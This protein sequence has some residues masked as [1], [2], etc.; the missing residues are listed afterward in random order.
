M[1]CT[2]IHT[3]NIVVNVEYN[4]NITFVYSSNFYR[5]QLEVVECL[6]AHS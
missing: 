4:T 2:R 6:T 3:F 5:Y 1:L